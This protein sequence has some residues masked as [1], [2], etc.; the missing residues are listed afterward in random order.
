M[1]FEIKVYTPEERENM[2]A[3]LEQLATN[4]PVLA[5][6][7]HDLA[8]MK[9]MP[10]GVS[11]PID[12]GS[13]YITIQ[14]VIKFLL[15]LATNK[16]A[17]ATVVNSKKGDRLPARDSPFWNAEKMYNRLFPA[18]AEE[19]SDMRRTAVIISAIELIKPCNEYIEMCRLIEEGKRNP[20]Q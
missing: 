16:A 1:S 10:P 9:D 6:V 4:K 3:L 2:K 8:C 18:S 13:G 5:K 15:C 17:Y 14:P 19:F 11:T 20:G 12:V 7:L